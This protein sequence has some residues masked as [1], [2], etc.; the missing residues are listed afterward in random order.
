M[1][2]MSVGI[3]AQEQ[4]AVD[5]GEDYAA[6]DQQEET[7]IDEKQADSE[8]RKLFSNAELRLALM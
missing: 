4:E 7:D 2:I 5:N 1:I 6:D 3:Y 8:S